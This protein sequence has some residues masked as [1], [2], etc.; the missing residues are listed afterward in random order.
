MAMKGAR[1][2]ARAG[3]RPL[4]VLIAA[5]ATGG[6]IFP[7]LAVAE[8]LRSRWAEDP[9]SAACMIEFVGTVRGLESRVISK[10][11]FPLHTVPAAGLKR[12]GGFQK[13]RNLLVLPRSFW[14]T[15]GLL[16]SFKPQVVVGVGGYVA[17]PVMLEAS[18]LRIPTLLIEPNAQPGFTNRVLAPF[19]RMAALGFK[20]AAPFYGPKARVTGHPV[21]RV[22]SRIP[23][24]EHVPPFTI[25]ILGGSQGAR[26]LN[27]VLIEALPSFAHEGMRWRIIHQSGE[28]DYARV[29][30]AYEESG[31]RGEVHPFIDDV[32]QVLSQADLVVCR[33]GAS[34]LAELMAAGKASLLVPF[35]A[36]ADDHQL[37]NAQVLEREGAAR[38]LEQRYLTPE[39]LFSEVRM[40]S[41]Q[42]ETITKMDRKA[43]E[44]SH[45]N[46]AQEIADLIEGLAR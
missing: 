26:T 25:L 37:V 16:W 41:S 15:W 17:G 13:V 29:R 30:Q 3:R 4:R 34:T 39:S 32:P 18:L 20:E 11:G 23:P 8:E 27:S 22:F 38:L 5:G 21:R 43:R 9:G 45:P 42:P 12:I 35:P 19:I 36:A 6:H 1:A 44:L 40:L 7:A 33:A 2:G 14:K 10:A 28:R 46:A 24:R 31:V